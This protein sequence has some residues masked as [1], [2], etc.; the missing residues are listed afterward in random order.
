MAPVPS[1][2]VPKLSLRIDN[3]NH[4]GASIFLKA[5]TPLSALR[6][7]CIASATW[8]YTPETAPTSVESVTLI[9]CSM[10]G[11]AYTTGTA[12][13]K[14]IYYSL[15]YIEHTKNRA[16]DEILGVL[17][18]EAVHCFQHNAE[19]TCNGGL[20]EG[21]ADYVRLRAGFDPP[22]WKQRGGD[23]WDAGYDTT[24]FFLA[25]IEKQYGN[26]TVRKLNASLEV[27]PY[28]DAV[29]KTVT[30]KPVKE[31]WE[32]YRGYLAE[33]WEIVDV[34]LMPRVLAR[35]RLPSLSSFFRKV[36]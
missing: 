20:I 7:A 22:H 26:G 17:V 28:D 27:G 32:A 34:P 6:D 33:T 31:L 15:E 24:G 18:H 2:T 21:I 13:H 23:D 9:L 10:N 1:W 25:W 3:L 36:W 4:P 16:R 8:L 29:F 14:E 12:Q 19:G 5:V 35:S 11:V 30:G